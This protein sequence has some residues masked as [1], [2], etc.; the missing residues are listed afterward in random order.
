MLEDTLTDIIEF[1]SSSV[2]FENQNYNFS[3]HHCIPVEG[4][5]QLL[6]TDGLRSYTQG[7]NE[8]NKDL[9]HIELYFCLPD[10]WNLERNP[11]PLEW[12]N[13]LA[14]VPQKNNTWYGVGDTIPAGNP[15]AEL[16]EK[17]TANHFILARPNLL[18]AQ[19]S[20]KKWESLP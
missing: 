12:L 20:G 17:F 15:P 2:I 18:A 11:W 10:Y 6:I 9:A 7:V 19:F 13:K 16:D 3:I 4:N 5:Y 14:E 8:D 1:K